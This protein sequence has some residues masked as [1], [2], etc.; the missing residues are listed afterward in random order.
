MT[1]QI[2][3]KDSFTQQYYDESILGKI[4]SKI[5]F[6]RIYVLEENLKQLTVKP[7][8]ALDVGCG[9][10]FTCQ[11]IFETNIN[12]CYVGLDLI[13]TKKLRQYRNLM[14]IVTKGQIEVIR[15]SAESLPFKTGTFDFVSSLDVLEHL[16]KP[17]NCAREINRVAYS[18]GLITISLPLENWL[19]R[20][21]R[22]GFIYLKISGQEESLK[23]YSFMETLK[24]VFK[25]PQYHYPSNLRSYDAMLKMLNGFLNKI[26]TVYTPA[27]IFGRMNINA[28]SFF[29]PNIDD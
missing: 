19:Q 24:W 10:M 11:A 8:L 16:Q 29:K 6:S 18:E 28:V 26:G 25:T 5:F 23:K 3:K 9:S 1:T 7:K 14:R 27:K 13:N 4:Q 2:D 21:F 12:A 15:A 20:L 22:L 17:A